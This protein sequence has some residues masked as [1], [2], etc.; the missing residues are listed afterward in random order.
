MHKE[1]IVGLE[2]VEYMLQERC[3]VLKC[4]YTPQRWSVQTSS[5][6]HSTEAM[7]FV[8]DRMQEMNLAV[9]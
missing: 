9:P 1:G 7:C 5:D 6:D 2:S 8:G 4:N 3:D